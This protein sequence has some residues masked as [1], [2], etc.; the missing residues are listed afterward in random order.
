M[1][2]ET[3]HCSTYYY[4]SFSNQL[5]EL[6]EYHVKKMSLMMLKISAW[7]NWYHQNFL[8]RE[9]FYLN[10]IE[11]NSHSDFILTSIWFLMFYVYW[12]IVNF[13]R[14]F[15]DW[16]DSFI[17]CDIFLKDYLTIA[18]N[19]LISYF[20]QFLII[21]WNLSEISSFI[22]MIEFDYLCY[23]RLF[24]TI[25]LIFRYVL[26]FSFLFMISFPLSSFLFCSFL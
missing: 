18:V 10:F 17:L 15:Y 11:L 5:S 26:L 25:L 21:F 7:F 6:Q 8:K 19:A 4:L 14:V 22:Y 23:I 24:F 13:L 1:I 2:S 3:I 16:Q 20:C 12:V 9:Y